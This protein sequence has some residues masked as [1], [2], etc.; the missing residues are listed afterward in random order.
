MNRR[1]RIVNWKSSVIEI[2]IVGNFKDVVIRSKTATGNEHL[3]DISREKKKENR[4]RRTSRTNER[5]RYPKFGK[6]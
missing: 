5:T 6:Q 3:I 2:R 1:C 4:K